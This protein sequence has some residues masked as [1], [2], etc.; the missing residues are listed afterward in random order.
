MGLQLRVMWDRLIEQVVAED[1]CRIA[2]TESD[3]LPYLDGELLGL[4]V[5][6]NPGIPP[7]VIDV[8]AGLSARG[9]VH[10]E[11]HVKPGLARPADDAIEQSKALVIAGKKV[12][13]MQ[14]NPD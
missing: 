11:N 3:A 8:R 12:F 14:G 9:A 5:V 1:R 4:G 7:A 13:V 10:V 6:V 2:V